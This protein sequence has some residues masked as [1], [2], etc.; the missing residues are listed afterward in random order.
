VASGTNGNGIALAGGVG[1]YMAELIQTGNTDLST[2][3]VDIRR[4]MRLHTNKR[5]LKDRVREIP[6]TS[7]PPLSLQSSSVCLSL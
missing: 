6:G 3:P 7:L 2:W 5:F 4:F 1:K